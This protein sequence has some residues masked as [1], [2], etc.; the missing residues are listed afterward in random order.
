MQEY[1]NRY[2]VRYQP[3]HLKKDYESYEE[4]KTIIPKLIWFARL[5]T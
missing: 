1:M 3:L 5:G 2:H 4:L